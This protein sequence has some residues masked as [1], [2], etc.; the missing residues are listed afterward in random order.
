MLIPNTKNMKDFEKYGFKKCKGKYGKSNC[1]Y[2]CISRGVQML[3]VSPYC[4]SINDWKDN[5][6][7]IHKNPNCKYKDTRTSLDILY[8]LIK[9]NMLIKQN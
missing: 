3:F 2:L 5:D 8:E 9:D 7:R 1:Y 4:F 6:P